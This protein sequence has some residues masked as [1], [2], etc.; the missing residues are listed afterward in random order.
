MQDLRYAYEHILASAVFDTRAPVNWIHVD[1][2]NI[3]ASSM[4][5]VSFNQQLILSNDILL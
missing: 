5:N 4:K 1:I 3:S 2:S